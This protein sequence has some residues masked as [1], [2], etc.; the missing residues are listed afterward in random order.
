VYALVIFGLAASVLLFLV[1]ASR[2]ANL[3]FKASVRDGKF[4]ALRGRAPKRLMRD[5]QDVLRVRPVPKADLRVIVRDKRPFLEAKGDVQEQEL[6]RLRNVLGTWEIAKI[7]SA[8]YRAGRLD[9]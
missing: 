5:L 1:I 9:G 3:L 2:N 4:Q 8:P 7:R 6:Q